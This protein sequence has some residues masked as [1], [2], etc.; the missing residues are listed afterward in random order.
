MVLGLFKAT[1]RP[2]TCLRVMTKNSSFSCFMVIFMSVAHS[3]WVVGGVA[4]LVK[5]LTCFRVMTKNS[6]LSCFMVIF[7][8]FAHIVL[9]LGGFACLVRIHKCLRDMTRNSSF[10]CYMAIFMIYCPQFWG[11]RE[12]YNGL[13]TRYMFERYDQKHFVF[14]FYGHFH[15]LLP[16]V[17][18]FQ[19]DLH[20]YLFQ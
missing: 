20:P 1:L 9:V 11:S 13:K 18:G 5:T 4:C 16:T 7:M 14:V 12:I 17:I 3:F 10:S 2:D 6:S 19:E 8:S 15:E